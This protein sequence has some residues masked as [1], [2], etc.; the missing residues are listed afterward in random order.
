MLHDPIRELRNKYE[1]LEE[2][3][4][5]LR[6]RIAVLTGQDLRGAARVVFGMTEAEATIFLTIVHL[7]RVDYGQLRDAVYSSGRLIELDEPHGA[8]RTHVKRLRK[9]AAKRGIEFTSI[10]SYGYEMPEEMRQRARA[11]LRKGAS[12]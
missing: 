6:D 12:K 10:Y 3:N 1:I 7:G 11:V 2:E 8:L 9:K 4:R 5:Q